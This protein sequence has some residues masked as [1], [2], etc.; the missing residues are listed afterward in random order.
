[1]SNSV[2]II[3]AMLNSKQTGDMEELQAHFKQIY[4][5]FLPLM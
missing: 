1:M 5:M 3:K 2:K 4:S